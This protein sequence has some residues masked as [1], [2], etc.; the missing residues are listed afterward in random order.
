MS[1][2]KVFSASLPYDT[3]VCFI[4]INI[5]SNSLPKMFEH[6]GGT[7]KV[8]S[9]KFW[10]FKNDITS[11]WTINSNHINH[12]IRNTSTP[13][14]RNSKMAG[15]IRAALTFDWM[16]FSRAWKSAICA[17]TTSRKPPASPASTIAT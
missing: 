1:Y 2:D 12:T 9:R 16:S 17:S 5:V 7:R 6:S 15:Y 10:M 3:R 8:Q 11:N 4:N 13:I 14:A